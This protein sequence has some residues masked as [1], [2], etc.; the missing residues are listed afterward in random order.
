T[1]L[2]DVTIDAVHRIVTDVS[3][4][5]KD[6]LEKCVEQGLSKE[7]Y[8]EL[9]GIVVAV[10]S[11]DAFHRAIGIENEKLPKPID[12]EPSHYLPSSIVKGQA[13]VPIIPAGA[14]KDEELDLYDG[15]KVTGNVLSAMS[16]VPDSVRLLKSLASVQYL[17]AKEV[18][19]P[20]MNG[21][22]KISRA[23]MELLAGRVSSLSAC[24][25]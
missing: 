5:T 7:K 19:N 1:N 25:Y 15:Q 14:A 20:S 22:R 9:L 21:G 6:W 2:N 11:I 23:Q 3:R 16:L 10:I 18:V 4:L 13:W 17:D 12:G 8:I 24:F